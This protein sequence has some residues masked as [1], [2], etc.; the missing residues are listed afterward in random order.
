MSGMEDD[1]PT[2]EPVR[3]SV[4]L[5]N[6]H[7]EHLDLGGQWYATADG[8]AYSDPI[9]FVIDCPDLD[10]GGVEVERVWI[11][12]ADGT[13]LDIPVIRPLWLSGRGATFRV[14]PIVVGVQ[15]L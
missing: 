11:R 1:R 5:S 12:F 8:F 14:S 2:A 15:G 10:E 4:R 13:E 7:V 9:R 6:N 3:A